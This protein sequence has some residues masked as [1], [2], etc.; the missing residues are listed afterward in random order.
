MEACGHW[1]IEITSLLCARSKAKSATCLADPVLEIGWG[2][3]LRLLSF[4]RIRTKSG[5]VDAWVSSAF[6]RLCLA[7]HPSQSHHQHLTT[8]RYYTPLHTYDFFL[9]T[10]ARC[11]R[12]SHLPLTTHCLPRPDERSF[13]VC[14]PRLP[15]ATTFL[16]L[17]GQLTTVSAA[18]RQ[19]LDLL[20]CNHHN[21]HLHH[22][23]SS[24]PM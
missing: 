5:P 24:Q 4:P 11:W 20:S 2:P 22:P 6:A 13:H 3:P 12:P 23:P 19:P 1:N 10:T 15:S 8:S 16:G 21:A 18:V 7:R 14:P 9:T 17:T